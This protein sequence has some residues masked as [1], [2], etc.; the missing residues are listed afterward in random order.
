MVLGETGEMLVSWS[1]RQ[2]DGAILPNT[3]SWVVTNTSSVTYQIRVSWPLCW[4]SREVQKQ[5]V[6]AMY[7]LLAMFLESACR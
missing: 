5:R 6:H 1:F 3:A 7:E 4:T 2:G